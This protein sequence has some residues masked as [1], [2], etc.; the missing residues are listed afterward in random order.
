[1]QLPTF[2]ILTALADGPKHGYA[3]IEQAAVLSGGET[4]LK[5]GTLYTALERLSKEGLIVRAGRLALEAEAER[6]K[7]LAA[8]ASLRLSGRLALP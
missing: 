3:L 6:M 5:V 7:A 4:Q 1:M 8:Q 2:L